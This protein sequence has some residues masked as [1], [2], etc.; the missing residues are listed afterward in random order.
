MSLSISPLLVAEV[1]IFRLSISADNL[2][3]A[4]S[5]VVRVLVLGS[6]NKLAIVFPRR[7]GTFFT[8]LLPTVAK[9]S[10]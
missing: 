6:K 9:D 10:A 1:E 5:K 4:S 7:S 8:G 2:F 3:A